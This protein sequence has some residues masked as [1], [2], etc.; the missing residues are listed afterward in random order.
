MQTKRWIVL[1]GLLTTLLIQSCASSP[2]GNYCD[3][4]RDIP[5]T[6]SDKTTAQ[7]M[8]RPAREGLVYAR[9]TYRKKCL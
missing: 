7:T 9:G 2:A 1:G 8:S 4:A 6:V 3:T 5:L